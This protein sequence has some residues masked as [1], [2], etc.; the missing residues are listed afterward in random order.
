MKSAALCGNIATLKQ[1]KIFRGS[2]NS[3]LKPDVC[4]E[5]AVEISVCVGKHESYDRVVG[6][7]DFQMKSHSSLRW[8][9]LHNLQVA[10]LA[11]KFGHDKPVE[12]S[13]NP[14]IHDGNFVNALCEIFVTKA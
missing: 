10:D 13:V 9:G 5:E 14:D 3:M 11:N 12:T 8:R 6:S 7:L 4:F 2:W 1:R